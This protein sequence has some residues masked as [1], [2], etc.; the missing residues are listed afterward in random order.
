MRI[1][2]LVIPRLRNGRTFACRD[3]HIHERHGIVQKG[4]RPGGGK[5]DGKGVHVEVVYAGRHKGLDIVGPVLL[6]G[7]AAGADERLPV[8]SGAAQLG[9]DGGY[10]RGPILRRIFGRQAY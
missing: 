6:P 10:L 5:I 9:D 7:A 8:D 4:H 2:Q 3:G 1:G